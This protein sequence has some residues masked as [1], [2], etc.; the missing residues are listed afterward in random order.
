MPARHRKMNGN[1]EA[2]PRLR[3]W[4]WSSFSLQ[5]CYAVFLA[6]ATVMALN[7]H[8]MEGRGA[9]GTGPTGIF[10]D[11]GLTWVPGEEYE[12]TSWRIGWPYRWL[13]IELRDGADW[14]EIRLVSVTNLAWSALCSS[15]AGLLSFLTIRSALRAIG[16]LWGGSCR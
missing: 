10:G 4:H 3:S 11:N 15:G 12:Y 6:L 5:S 16:K 7:C 9:G 8:N 1:K 2:L 14:P 13:S